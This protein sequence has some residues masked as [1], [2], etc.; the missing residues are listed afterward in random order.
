L[1]NIKSAKKRVNVAETKRQ[2]NRV[3]LSSSRTRLRRAESLINQ[4]D[5]DA[6]AVAVGDAISTLDRATVKGIIHKNAASR[7]KS[8]LMKKF[9]ALV[10]PDGDAS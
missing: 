9:N 2:R 8:R 4:G 5:A 1:P 7:R 3:F 6:A 10:R